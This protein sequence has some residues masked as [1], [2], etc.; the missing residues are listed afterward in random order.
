[1]FSE[2]LSLECLWIIG[3]LNSRSVEGLSVE[4]VARNRSCK[5]LFFDIFNNFR[6]FR[7]RTS[8]IE[9][10]L[11]IKLTSGTRKKTLIVNGKVVNISGFIIGRWCGSW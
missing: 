10:T 2:V 11:A 4:T 7:S 1:M 3:I 5:I 6:L 9:L 8:Q